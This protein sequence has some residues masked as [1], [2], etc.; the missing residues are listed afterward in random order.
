LLNYSKWLEGYHD[1]GMRHLAL[2]AVGKRI[3]AFVERAL[4]AARNG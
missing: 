1:A 2:E 3:E 4:G